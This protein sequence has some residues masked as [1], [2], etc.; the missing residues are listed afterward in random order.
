ML[1][2]IQELINQEFRGI[3]DTG[4]KLTQFIRGELYFQVD[5]LISL[6]A[7]TTTEDLPAIFDFIQEIFKMIIKWMEIFPKYLASFNESQ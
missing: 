2:Q 6:F 5:S 1:K 7:N 4:Y 3:H